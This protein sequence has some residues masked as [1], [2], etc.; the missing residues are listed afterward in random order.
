MAGEITAANV[1]NHIGARYFQ[2]TPDMQVTFLKVFDEANPNEC[3]Q[4]KKALCRTRP[5]VGQHKLSLQ[6]ARIL[7]SQITR[8]VVVRAGF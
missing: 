6:M 5:W 4:R 3:F 7:E 8:Q 1:S 2:H